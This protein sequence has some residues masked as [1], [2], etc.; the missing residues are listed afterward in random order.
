ML[1]ISQYMRYSQVFYACKSYSVSYVAIRSY[2]Y[3][4]ATIRK[5][6]LID[7][8]THKAYTAILNISQLCMQIASYLYLA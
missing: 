4:H 3:R 5:W 6:W 2:V 1:A 7:H 8:D